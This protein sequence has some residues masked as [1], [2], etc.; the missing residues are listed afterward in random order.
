MG[1]VTVGE[2]KAW[3]AEHEV[4]D[5]YGLIL[6]VWDGD[7]SEWKDLNVGPYSLIPLLKY[8]ELYDE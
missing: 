1:L 6:T 5:D 3:F 7:Y 2:L 4:P 8:V